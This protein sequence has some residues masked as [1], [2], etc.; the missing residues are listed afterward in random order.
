MS[1]AFKRANCISR[2]RVAARF[3]L[4]S[5]H[6]RLV[7]GTTDVELLDTA[8]MCQRRQSPISKFSVENSRVR[9]PAKVCVSQ[10]NGCSRKLL[11][12]N[13]RDSCEVKDA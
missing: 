4:G 5:A 8:V 3:K 2:L 11:E 1:A 10:S 7:A 13:I 6:L 12:F 9:W